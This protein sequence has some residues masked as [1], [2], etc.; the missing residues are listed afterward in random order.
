MTDSPLRLSLSDMA[1]QMENLIHTLIPFKRK[2]I[3]KW[4]GIKE[5]ELEHLAD[6][7]D[8][9]IAALKDEMS[10][11]LEHAAALGIETNPV[12]PYEREP[13]EKPNEKPNPLADSKEENLNGPHI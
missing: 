1:V 12:P 8:D 3:H 7:Y 4:E 5:R 6:W 2:E 13:D 11:L 10:I 9:H